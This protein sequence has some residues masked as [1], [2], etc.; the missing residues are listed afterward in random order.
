MKKIRVAVIGA[1]KLGSIHARIYSQLKEVNLVGI[2]DIDGDRAKEVADT[3][4]TISFTDYRKLLDKVDGVSIAVPTV[5][6]Y[7]IGREFLSKGVDCL[8]EKPITADLKEARKLLTLADK[9]N[10]ILQVGHTER[11]NPVLK[12][13]AD[14][15]GTPRFIECH[16][17]G[18]F[19]P[20]VKDIGV[21][22]DLMIHDID[23]ILT[24]I[25]SKIKSLD[26]IGIN[27]LTKHEDIANARIKFV[28]GAICNLTASRVSN[29]KMRKIRIFKEKAYASLDYSQQEAVIY[30]KIENQIVQKI[31]PTKKEEPLKAQ[32]ISFIRCIKT[33]EKPLVSGQDA[34]KALELAFLILDK[35]HGQK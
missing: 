18:Q 29:E 12:A 14:I 10:C 11:F 35:I 24:L 20:R 16:R 25:R 2:C 33:G 32:L 34:Y 27:V 4:G 9:K 22:L 5:L 26:A 17:L 7:K 23:I 8:I 19:S 30:R 3:L 21:V 28:N 6:H 15:P 31:I 1:G 13:I